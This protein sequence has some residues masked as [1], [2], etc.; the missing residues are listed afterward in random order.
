MCVMVLLLSACSD[1]TNLSEEERKATPQAVIDEQALLENYNTT[2]IDLTGRVQSESGVPVVNALIQIVGSALTASSNASGDFS[3]TGLNRRNVLLQ[4]SAAG[5]R[6]EYIPVYLQQPVTINSTALPTI[7]LSHDTDSRA[8]LLFG[9]DVAFGR[10][11]LDIDEST[12]L[13]QVPPDDS[14]ALIQAGNPDPGTR[15]VLSELRPY[16]QEADLGVFNFET[17]VTDTPI[18]PHQEKDFV[19][20]TLPGSLPAISWLG[21]DYVSMGNNHVYDYL[22]GGVSDTINHL[23]NAGIPFAGAGL[24]SND[25]FAAYR[26]SLKS[27]NYGFLA[28]TSIG[29]FQHSNNYVAEAAKGG[30]ANLTKDADVIAAIQGEQAAGHIPIVQFHTGDEYIFEPTDYVLSR[31][32]L[33]TNENVPLAVLHHPHVAQGV[34]LFGNTWAV[35]GLGNLAFDQARLETMLGVMA[36]VDMNADNVEQIRMLPVYLEAYSPKLISGR[37]AHNF[38]RRLGEFSHAYGGL[39]YPYNGQGWVSMVPTDRAVVDRSINITVN[40]PASDSASGSGSGSTVVDLREVLQW[41]ESLYSVN[42]TASVTL[43][44]GRDLMQHGDFE[45][46]DKDA[47]VN[48][49]ARWDHSGDSRLI[50]QSHAYKGNAALCLMRKSVNFDDT[51]AAFRNRIRVM[52]DAHDLPN[53]DLSLFGYY[54]GSNSGAMSIVSRYYASFGDL[55]FGEEVALQH[56]GGTFSW[57]AFNRR[58][59]MPADVFSNGELDARA[60]RV[61]IHQSPPA[62]GEGLAVFDELAVIAWENTITSAQFLDVPHAKDFLKVSGSA[63]TVQLS[64]QLRKFVP[65]ASQ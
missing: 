44:Q 49:V 3:L 20:F 55:E 31:I 14:D 52:G 56:P 32:Q 34:G 36:R 26:S 64:L 54:K 53:K 17:P 38:L 51:V 18:T 28:M 12:P 58:L 63:G 65:S 46:W 9:G 42:T 61:F 33:A 24:N 43:Q 45:D 1:V 11:F 8:R 5:F 47:D 19:F 29:G 16:Y 15:A 25:A 48:E 21:V 7:V 37:L 59:N 4:I 6:I 30:A 27:N 40:I 39:L 41:G 57:Q 60:L 13:N 22:E 62:S 2:P 35:L 50:C 23:N 10:R